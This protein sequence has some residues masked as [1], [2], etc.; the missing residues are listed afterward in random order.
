MRVE[1]EG[2]RVSLV[3]P[4]HNRASWL[5]EAMD[6][7]LAQ[8]YPNLELLVV[9]DGSTD[10][11]PA[12]LADYG[13]R[14]SDERFRFFRQ[15]NSGQ[16]NA[17]NRGNGLAR[18]EILGYLS[19]DDLLAP[20]AVS[21]LASELIANPEAAVAYPGYRTIDEVGAVE[22]TVRPIEYSS[23]AALR[24]HD[25]IIGPGGLARRWALESA[26]GWDPSYRWMGD[27]ILWMGVGLAGRAI[28]VDEPLASW[29]KHSG[30]VTIELSPDHAREHVA[31]VEHGLAMP[32]LP[33]LSRSIRAE[34]LRNACLFG[35]LFGGGSGTWPQ[36]RFVPFDL[37]RK[38]ISAWSSGFAAGSQVD[39]RAAEEGAEA[40]RKLIMLTAELAELRGFRSGR[41]I[42]AAGGRAS[43]G[44]HGLVAGTA[45]A[46]QLL[47]RVGVLPKDDGSYLEVV[48]EREMRS[49]LLEAAVACGHETELESSRFFILDR[50]RAPLSDAELDALLS[51]TIGGPRDQLREAVNRKRRELR[52]LRGTATE[53]DRI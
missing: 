35:A 48:D 24:L 32:G 30:S 28:R 23:V 10:E 19:D 3:I 16:A 15:D 8:D 53:P 27:L 36:E 22:D 20:D 37:H 21:R 9:D 33:P 51:L 34:A 12:I 49:G 31:V 7:V 26:G 42:Q 50:R 11:T 14:H 29:R 47:R 18:G 4:T 44:A 17:L 6:S 45:A 39:W 41:G 13:G 40:C 25:T 52:D 5:R 38:R 1:G 2:P 46:R 43:S